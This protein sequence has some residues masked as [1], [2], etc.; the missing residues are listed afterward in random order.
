MLEIGREL[1]PAE[2]AALQT[3]DR[4]VGIVVPYHVDDRY[5]V[6]EGGGQHVRVHEE[7]PVADHGHARPMGRSE[8]RSQRAGDTETHG[9]EAH[10]ADQRIGTLGLA[11]LDQP[12][13]VDADIADQYR[14]L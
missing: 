8:L 4:A 2:I 3:P 10:R 1:A 14:V 7:S 9:A 6:L 13:V 11:E 12:V 5:L